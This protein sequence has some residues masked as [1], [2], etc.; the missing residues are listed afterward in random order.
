MEVGAKELVE[1]GTEYIQMRDELKRSRNPEVGAVAY[2]IS[3]PWI[4]KYKTYIHYDAL[5]TRRDPAQSDDHCEKN[6]P[7]NIVNAGFLELD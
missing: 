5:R 2:L 6:N 3:K 4:E 7:G 1:E